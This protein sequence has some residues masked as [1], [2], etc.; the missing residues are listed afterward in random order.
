MLSQI[1][2]KLVSSFQLYL[3]HL[4]LNKGQSYFNYSGTFYPINSPYN[5]YYTYGGEFAGTVYDN[6]DSGA[7]VTNQVYINNVLVGTGTSGFM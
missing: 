1:D 5:G 4:I 6:S 7:N 3:D 2:N